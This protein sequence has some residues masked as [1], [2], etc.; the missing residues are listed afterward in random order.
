MGAER[1][2][3]HLG[4][5]RDH[6]RPVEQSS[7][8]PQRPRKT[9]GTI[10]WGATET[11]EDLWNNHLGSHRDHGR[12]HF[13]RLRQ[14]DRL[15]SGVGDQRGQHGEI[16]CLLKIQKIRRVCWRV[17]VIPTAGEAEARESLEPGTWRLQGAEMGPRHSSRGD[18]DWI[19]LPAAQSTARNCISS[20]SMDV[21]VFLA[22]PLHLPFKLCSPRHLLSSFLDIYTKCEEGLRRCSGYYLKSQHFGRPMWEDCWWPGLRDQ[23]GEHS[24]TSSPLKIFK[25]SGCDGAHL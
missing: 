8:E 1:G 9:C 23:T 3:N 13:G 17:P 22:D 19:S 2:N 16:L 4:S 20:I 12:P 14:V 18:T 5:H 11:T 10:I 25:V 24:K 7:G 21:L 15:R 6:G